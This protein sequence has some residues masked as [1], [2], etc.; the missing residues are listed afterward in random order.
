MYKSLIRPERESDQAA[1]HA[2]H[3]SAFPTPV[4]ARLVD[5]LRGA[6]RLTV[7]LVAEVDGLVVGH[8]A[9]SPVTIA[10]AADGL[11]LA[12]VAV[13]PVHQRCGIG[14]LLVKESLAAAA[15]LGAGLVVVLGAREYY[16]RFGF[17]PAADWGLMDEYGGGSAF[18][19][20]ELRAG[21]I[22]RGAGLVRYAPEFAIV[23]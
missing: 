23:A 22:P 19:V 15:Q 1:I 2:V 13:L 9:L 12:P 8:V 16:G 3:A 11:G 14:G 7:S 20:I 10:G 17:Q 4:E 21:A 6:S 5:A 18:Q